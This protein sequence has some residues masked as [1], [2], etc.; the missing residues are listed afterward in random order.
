MERFAANF[1]ALQNREPRRLREDF[2]GTFLHCCEWVSMHKNNTAVGVDNDAEVLSWAR[3][4]F[5][6][7]F[8]LLD[9]EE[10]ARIQ[11]FEQDVL[12][13]TVAAGGDAKNGFDLI[14]ALNFSYSIFKERAKL[15]EYFRV[16]KSSL[17]ADGLF[18]LDAHG[19]RTICQ[20]G[21]KVVHQVNGA[22]AIE[23]AGLD[24]VEYEWEQVSWDPITSNL[25]C[26]IHF[27]FPD[28]SRLENAFEYDWR[29]W[30]LAEL[31]DV[32]R[33]AG[34]SKL[35]VFWPD[36]DNEGDLTGTYSEAATGR[37]D[38][39]FSAYIAAGI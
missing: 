35:H 26:A 5:G 7:P 15:L 4:E 21:L 32:L 18:F 10:Q 16:V 25:Q 12:K 8:G 33:D 34:F 29:H 2:C 1:K 24:G 14:C 20:S 13:T 36:V 39:T 19:G 9:E 30:R 17:A 11:T 38:E 23:E 6:S 31:Q 27:A 3:D 37:D 22:G 28:G